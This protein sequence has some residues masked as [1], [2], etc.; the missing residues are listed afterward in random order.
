MIDQVMDELE[1]AKQRMA[2]ASK[3]VLDGAKQRAGVAANYVRASPW[4]AL[5]VAIAAGML[6]GFLA[7]KR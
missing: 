7:A 2:A 1:Q 6:L 3:P 4:A 5:G